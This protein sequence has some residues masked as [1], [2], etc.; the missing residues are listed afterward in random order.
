MANKYMDNVS[1]KELATSLIKGL[2]DYPGNDA[3]DTE[4]TKRLLNALNDFSASLNAEITN[5]R[6]EY[7][8]QVARIAVD[9]L[10]KSRQIDHVLIKNGKDRYGALQ[11]EFY[12]S[13]DDELDGKD[14]NTILDADDPD[15]EFASKIEDAY[16]GEYARTV[17]SLEDEVKDAVQMELG[18][19]DDID[20]IV[21]DSVAENIIFQYPF[22]HYLNQEVRVPIMLDTGDA[23]YDYTLNRLMDPDAEHPSHWMHEHS[24]AL[25]L[26]K[27]QGYT[28][29][30][31]VEALQAENTDDIKDEFL[32]DICIEMDSVVNRVGQLVF[33]TKLTVKELL[34]LNM[35]MKTGEGSITITDPYCG[36]FDKVNGAGG[37][38]LRVSKPVEIPVK[39]IQSARVDVPHAI[40]TVWNY[41]I[42]ETF[43]FIGAVW[44]DS[45]QLKAKFDFPKAVTDAFEIYA[46][47]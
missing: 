31:L 23:G 45:S 17:E 33:L 34:A 25:W 40:N 7:E 42:Q 47:D 22:E 44:K 16:S 35:A 8:Q 20:D 28:E 27:Q 3:F 36:L 43:D 11:I 39:F 13:Y 10:K 6:E 1:L 21:S 46:Q 26:A 9:A 14:I 4:S 29:A 37:M 15:S 38:E 30:Q 32:R 24:S 18:G 12:A 2:S 41:G 19:V 5:T